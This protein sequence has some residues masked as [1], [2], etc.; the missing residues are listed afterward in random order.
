M[1]KKI[2][3]NHLKEYN[4]TQEKGYQS[5]DI[6][7]LLDKAQKIKELVWTDQDLMK[8]ILPLIFKS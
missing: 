5:L 3:D 6:D 1:E 8:I 4:K 2:I 7:W